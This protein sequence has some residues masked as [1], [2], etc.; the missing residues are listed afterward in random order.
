[1]NSTHNVPWSQKLWDMIRLLYWTPRLVGFGSISEDKYPADFKV[2]KAL[3]GTGWRLYSRNR[4]ID[5]LLSYLNG[6]EEFL[7]L[8]LNI[9]FAIAPDEVLSRLL[10]TPLGIPDAGPFKSLGPRELAAQYG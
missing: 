2:P 6:Q 7:N 4:K 1:M 5:G 8:F 9:A 10:C 3:K